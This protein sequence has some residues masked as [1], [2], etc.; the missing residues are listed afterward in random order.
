MPQKQYFA[1]TLLGMSSCASY[2]SCNHDV[3]DDATRSQSR[4]NFEIDISQSI[5]EL[6]R[7]YR[8]WPRYG[9]RW[10]GWYCNPAQHK[11]CRPS[12]GRLWPLAAGTTSAV[13]D[14]STN[15]D[16]ADRI[17]GQF[18]FYHD[19]NFTKSKGNLRFQCLVP[20]FVPISVY[21]TM[22][23]DGTASDVTIGCDVTI[24]MPRTTSAM[25]NLGFHSQSSLAM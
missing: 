19:H 12:H 5:F 25:A 18:L 7:R 3:L 23:D 15:H 11:L 17:S 16:S 14:C 22:H 20:L 13:L 2:V 4:S 21:V 6:E 10:S 24:N 1:G 8:N 9:L